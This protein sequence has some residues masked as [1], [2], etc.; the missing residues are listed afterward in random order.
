MATI[1]PIAPSWIRLTASS[2]G[3]IVPAVEARHNA[4]FLLLGQLA[5]GGKLA[6][7]DR[8]D[9]VRLLDEDVLAGLDRGPQIDA[10]ILRRAGH[11]H[12]VAALDHVLVAVEADKTMGVVHLD[13]VRL[14][15]LEHVAPAL[16]TVGKNVGQGHQPNAGVG[17]HGVDGCA[18]ATVS[19]ADQADADHVAAG[20]VGTA[21]QRQP[22]EGRRRGRPQHRSSQKVRDDSDV[23]RNR[24]FQVQSW[25]RSLRRGD[26]GNGKG[27]V[28]AK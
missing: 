8:I 12:D 28:V 13:L 7:A 10:V 21:G 2:I 4:Q 18:R 9:G 22:A 11:Q 6:H 5:G 14:L 3:R 19:A 24:V 26:G 15:L 17:R 23:Q 1:S 16:Q 25:Q 20:G 27:R